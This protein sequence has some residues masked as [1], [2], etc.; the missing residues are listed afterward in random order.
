MKTYPLTDRQHATVIAALR[1]YQAKNQTV[2]VDRDAW[3]DRIATNDGELTALRDPEVDDLIERLQLPTGKLTVRQPVTDIQK[4]CW[5]G[6]TAE[7]PGSEALDRA[8]ID[9]V[10]KVA[11]DHG[12][13]G[14]VNKVAVDPACDF[15]GEPN[16]DG[17]GYDGLCGNCA[18]RVVSSS[19]KRGM[20]ANPKPTTPDA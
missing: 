20:A 3:I 13:I 6:M 4:Q 11:L 9:V 16:D 1:Y 19:A 10:N 14:A 5:D 18:D 12:F 15:C 2:S 8:F 17:E 7:H